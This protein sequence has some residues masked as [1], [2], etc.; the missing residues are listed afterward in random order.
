MKEFPGL[1][2]RGS[3]YWLARQRDGK[4]VFISLETSDTAEAI[5][6]AREM[7]SHPSLA[8]SDRLSREAENFIAYRVGRHE[9]T[10][11]TA[12]S[13]KYVLGTFAEF[14][15]NP[16]LAS[17]TTADIQRFY[18]DAR[19]Q[20]SETTA[21]GQLMALRAFFRWAKE[22]RHLRR[23][24]P[25]EGVRAVKADNKGRKE[26][27][28]PTLRDRLIAECP[29]EDLRFVLFC[30]FHAGLRFNEIV[31][32]RAFWFD[33]KANL[34][35]LRKHEGIQFKDREE[36]TVPLTAAFRAF[37]DGYGLRE[38]YM[39]R[40]ERTHGKSLYRYDFGRPFDLYMEA[41]GVPWVTPHIMRHTFASLLA[42]AGVSIYKVASWLGDDVRVVQR[43][44]A[45]LLPGDM[46]I[47]KAFA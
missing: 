3:V 12:S 22:T 25:A 21:L 11:S 7:I 28:T 40:P 47:E 8:A 43:H 17:V 31:Q 34:L 33:L 23:D 16:P 39:L 42:S 35:H 30:G 2:R 26:F 13:K 20:R 29:R 37:L 4:R 14:L 41:Q 24:N 46:D 44:Y 38:P 19:R 36:R 6:R 5:R 10:A 32:A 1:Y 9:Y 27:C 45:K 15:G 18:D